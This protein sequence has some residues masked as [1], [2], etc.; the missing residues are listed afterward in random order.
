MVPTSRWNQHGRRRIRPVASGRRR[1][2]GPS[3]TGGTGPLARAA[4]RRGAQHRRR[5]RP[6]MKALLAID[7]SHE[8]EMAIETAASLT[9]PPD[10]R[11]EI[12]SVA[13]TEV[14]VYGG[15][16][17][18]G[19]YVQA[20]EVHE[21][22]VD[23]C[24]RRVDDAAERLRRPGLGIAARVLE[25][26]AA[27]VI[28]EEAE[29]TSAE[30]IIVGAREH[31]A[32]ERVL[33]GSVSAEVVDHAHCPVLVARK[34]TAWRVLVATDG[35]PDAA[36]GCGVRGRVRPVRRRRRPDRE[37]DRRARGL[38]A[39]VH[40]RRWH[41]RHG[42]LCVRRRPMPPDM[43]GRSPP[44][45]SVAS[46][47]RG[48]RPSRSSAR[49]RRRPRSSP[50]PSPGVP[51]WSSSGRAGTACSSGCSLAAPRGPCCITRRCRS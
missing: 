28:L 32:I 5:R 24:R 39:R 10:S 2:D 34:P 14:E 38:V 48:W 36:L 40:A 6:A 20:P 50:R 21:R 46:A 31:G 22:L 30:L 37:R 51:T 35:S 19:A 29:R 26:R 12:I 18:V 47:P 9:W 27:T 13:P 23:D 3:V 15:P 17:A 8:S 49:A 41:P 43:R 16:F 7:G 33:L 1:A 42:C 4:R 45:P 44:T 11:L 25:G